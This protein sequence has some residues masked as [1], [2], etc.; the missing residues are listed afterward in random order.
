MFL[1][2][3]NI[4]VSVQNQSKSRLTKNSSLIPCGVD[5]N[6]FVP[7][8]KLEA[9]RLSG[10]DL[11]KK[12]VLFAGAFTNK[13]KNPDLALN[14]IAKLND[15][16]LI[17]LKGYSRNQVVLLMNAVDLVLMT[18]FTEGSPQFIKEA[19][20]C[21]CPV[22]SVPV[23]DVPDVVNGIEGCF[24]SSYEPIDV[25]DKMN[26]ALD[27]GKRTEGRNKIIELELDVEAVAQKII[28]LYQKLITNR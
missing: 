10:L 15:V 14:A 11:N 3:H 9:R 2:V 22:V 24:I 6:L 4:F 8:E 26:M 16:E 20:A 19:M 25:A 7:I 18:S 5:I 1:S 27:F 12:Y 13:V 23:G 17:E 21:N 28:T